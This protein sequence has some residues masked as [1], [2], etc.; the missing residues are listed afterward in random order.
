[1]YKTQSDEALMHRLAQ[2][3]D[4]GAFAELYD[5]YSARMYRFFLR[6]LGR[7][8]AQAE[9]FTQDLFLKIIEKPAFFDPSRRFST[10]LY[11]LASNMCKNEY[12]RRNP[13]VAPDFGPE[14]ALP[15]AEHQPEYLDKPFLEH[16]LQRA[17]DRLDDT[18]RQCFVLRWQEELSLREIAD[19]VGCPEGTVKSRLH[20]ALRKVTQIFEGW[21][22]EGGR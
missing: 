20:H 8:A 7:N 1:M 13:F 2:Q 6:M 12:R 5:R 19:I 4:E 3:R 14:E 17:I 21:R 11:T 10:W 9:D 15:M 18:H 22:V 16:Q